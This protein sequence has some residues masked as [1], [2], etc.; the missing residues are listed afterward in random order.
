VLDLSSVC[1]IFIRLI[2]KKKF[3]FQPRALSH[4]F[5][6]KDHFT[7]IVCVL[8]FNPLKHDGYYLVVLHP[9]SGA[10]QI[11]MEG[12]PAYKQMFLL[13]HSQHVSAQIGHYQASHEEYTNDDRIH[14]R[15]TMLI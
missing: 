6:P 13:S 3:E 14:I 5:K 8:S 15:T 7:V 2:R 4:P 12:L 10:Y 9:V 1:P 11:K